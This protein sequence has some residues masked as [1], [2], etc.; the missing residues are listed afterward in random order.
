[1]AK[2]ENCPTCK[3]PTSER[4]AVCPSCGEPLEFGW[5]DFIREERR[6]AEEEENRLE[7]ERIAE[8]ELKVR[9]ARRTKIRIRLA[10]ASV[11]FLVVLYNCV[12]MLYGVYEF[13]QWAE[14]NPEEYQ[15]LQEENRAK[16]Q[17]EIRSKIVELEAE[18]AKV[19][20]ENFESN[21]RLYKSLKELDP[22]NEVYS[23]RLFFYEVEKEKAELAKQKAEQAQ[24]LAKQKAEQEERLAEERAEKEEEE[25]ER[26]AEVIKEAENKRKGFHCLSPW[27][28]T[29]RAVENYVEQNLRDPDS[30]EHIE[31]SITP[32]NDKGTHTLF[33]KYRAKN[34]FGGM[35]IGQVVATIQNAGCSATIVSSE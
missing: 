7:D 16:K 5:A 28:G 23:K 26:T 2:L 1:M 32:V 9:K 33:M 21:I 6:L 8:L 25:R 4:A 29:H 34:G 3:N 19:P 35:T 30:Y 11:I 24:R 14:D 13:N 31:T 15:Q 10:V 18:V 27:D 20:V 22:E 17:A 12:P